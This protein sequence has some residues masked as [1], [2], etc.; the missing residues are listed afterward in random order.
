MIGKSNYSK[1]ELLAAIGDAVQAF[2]NAT[3]EVDDAVARRL[4]LNRTDLR[5]L[6]VLA[7]SGPATPSALAGAA[8]LTRGAI[9]TALDRLEEGG[10]TKRV[11]DPEDRRSLRVELT[12]QARK[13]I[14]VLYAPL[15]R[16]G[17]GFLRK[18][19]RD[20][21]AAVVKFLVDGERLQRRHAE[22]IRELGSASRQRRQGVIP[23]N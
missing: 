16:E 9:T 5:C 8:G 19:T 21:L 7:R 14:G 3:D 6:S 17:E 20:E 13:D 23:K 22:R 4:G 10:F 12:D 1:N 11:L 18:Y 15:A 2:Q